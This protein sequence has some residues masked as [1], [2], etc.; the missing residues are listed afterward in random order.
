MFRSLSYDHHQWSITVLVQLLLIGVHT[1]SYSGLWL[2][3]VGVFCASDVPFLVVFVYVVQK[4]NY[5]FGIKP[6]LI[7]NCH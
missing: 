7:I 2:Y 4:A 6:A 1:S 5:V 3:V